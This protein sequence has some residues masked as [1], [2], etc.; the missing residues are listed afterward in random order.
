M[1]REPPGMAVTQLRSILCTFGFSAIAREIF[2]IP[3]IAI[4][5]VQPLIFE[6]CYDERFL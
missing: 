2:I 4:L 6:G 3:F 5:A 1:A